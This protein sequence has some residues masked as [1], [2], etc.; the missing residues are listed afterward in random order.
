MEEA[1][2]SSQQS[3][4]GEKIE[5]SLDAHHKLQ[6]RQTEGSSN[7]HGSAYA[8]LLLKKKKAFSKGNR[9][10]VVVVVIASGIPWM[11]GHENSTGRGV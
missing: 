10:A 9:N 11:L 7:A 4:G 3:S 8:R 5:I 2:S 6:W 1:S